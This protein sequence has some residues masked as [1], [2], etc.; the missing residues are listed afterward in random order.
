MSSETTAPLTRTETLELLRTSGRH[1]MMSAFPMGAFISFDHDLRYLSAG[2]LGL[3]GVGLSQELLEGRTLY[4]VFDPDTIAVLEPLYRAALAGEPTTW[5]VEYGGRIFA[6]HLA[7]VIG[8]DETVVAGMGFAVDITEERR[9]QAALRL[10]EERNRQ[11][12]EDAPI[13]MAIVDLDGTW[14]TVNAAV[15]RLLGY[16]A[17]ELSAMTFQDVTHPDDLDLDL[18]HVSQLL[19]GQIDT[20]EMEKRY[21]TKQGRTVWV[22][23]SGSVVRD[24]DGEPS[25]FIAQIQDITENKRQRDALHDLTAMLA[26]DLR[27]PCATIAGFAEIMT[28]NDAL[29]PQQVRNYAARIRSSAHTLTTLLDNSLTAAA[30]DAGELVAQP[31]TTTLSE[32]LAASIAATGMDSSLTVRADT[33]DEV[34]VHADPVHL[35]QVLSNLLTNARK[36]GGSTVTITA[37]SQDDRV[38]VRVHDDGPGVENDFVAHL[39]DRYSRSTGARQGATRGSGLGLYIVR[40]LLAANHGTITYESSATSG[41]AFVITLP[42]GTP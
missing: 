16:S 32:V 29:P 15:S 2:G 5:D 8:A 31:V 22:L 14:R 7:P 12:F 17:E 35:Q 9:T 40:D 37:T 23:L 25:Y 38:H 20:Y 41:A 3:A 42:A 34:R 11:I 6:Q 18:Q 27:T 30:M 1:P 10:S 4:E 19:A 28:D 21:F 13:G 39:F 36:Y 26:H 33:I 24:S